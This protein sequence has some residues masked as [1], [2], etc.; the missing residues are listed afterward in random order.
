MLKRTAYIFFGIIKCHCLIYAQAGS[1]A[2]QLKQIDVIKNDSL[3]LI[4]LESLAQAGKV[5]V[6]SQLDLNR[7]IITRANL[8]EKFNKAIALENESIV[9]AHNNGMDSA[10]A[11]FNK[12]LGAS[13]YFMDRKKACIPYFERAIAI[14]QK[15]GLW[16]LEAACQNNIGGALC[17][18]NKFDEAEPYMLR[19]VAMM[20]E[21]GKENSPL[22]LMSSRVLARL[23][24][25]TRQ[26]DKSEKLYLKLIEK[27]K[28]NKDTAFLS[29][30]LLFYSLLLAERG[31]GEKAVAMSAEALLYKRLGKNPHEIQAAVDLHGGN[32]YAAGRY[33]EAY[34]FM[35]EKAALLRSTFVKDLEKEISEVEVKYKT[36]Q[37]KHEKEIAEIKVKE[38]R[39]VFLFSSV[40]ILVFVACGIF[41]WNQKKRTKHFTELAEAEKLRFKDVIEAEEKERSRIAQDLHDGLG[42]LLSAAR[43]NVAGLEDSIGAE[44]KPDLNRSLKI[45][46]DACVEVRNISHN[47]MP[48]AL[49]RLGLIP[50]INEVV[51][52]V[53]SV[54]GIKINFN[55]NVDHSLGPSLDITIYRVVQEILNNMLKHAKADQIEMNI[56]RNNSD[57]HIS[58]KDNG[59][60]FDPEKLKESKGLGWKN[61]FSR[62]SMLD[63]NIKLESQPQKG[64]SV[65][66]NLKLKNG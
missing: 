6:R 33:K 8:M 17:D 54:K 31:E 22:G 44:D 56:E 18:L 9:I 14:A 38:Q 40:G 11:Y 24:S 5:D 39:Q 57:L 45:I 30:N 55:T 27:G 7:R 42:Q 2:T 32:L 16:E 43:L 62:I 46:D 51:N 64:T 60:G 25:E 36:E 58:I 59:I 50:A 20:K 21:H 48:S 1:I 26:W 66:I 28:E 10:E 3:A 12:L 23:Y 13:Y 49:I 63:G 65:Y 35:Q 61:I 29:D 37:I 15:N 52:N 34:N 41:V 53:N 4:S 19:A 47:M